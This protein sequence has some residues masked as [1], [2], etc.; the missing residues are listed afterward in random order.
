MPVVRAVACL[1]VF[2]TGCRSAG[3][4]QGFVPYHSTTLSL[5][6]VSPHVYLHTSFLETNRF[7]RVACNGMIVVDAGEAIVFDTPATE[8]ATIE[9]LD[10]A[11]RTLKVRVKAVVPTH[12]HADC[13][14]GLAEF[15]RRRIRSY[16]LASTLALAAGSKAEVP[17]QGFAER[18]ALRV[19][20]QE[21]IAHFLGEGHTKDNVVAYFPAEQVLFGGCL[22]KALGADKGFLGD[23]N[24][25]AWPQTVAK[26]KQ[27]YPHTRVL[28][29]GH[30]QAGGLELS[31]YTIQLF[32]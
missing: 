3:P 18:L 6:Q 7:G 27:T 24:V 4:D 28:I 30:G 22:I 17:Q 8:S 11:E 29:P 20:Q 9:L 31:D 21:V 1:L 13:L 2:L 25:R 5:E 16:A 12:F 10:Y 15:H 26:L 32:K 23:A 14:A 19:G